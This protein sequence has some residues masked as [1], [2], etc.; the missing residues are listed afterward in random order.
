MT[1]NDLFSE[2]QYGFRKHR[3]CVT[4]L[5]AV[6]ENLKQLIDNGYPD[7][8]VYLDLKKKLLIPFPIKGGCVNLPLIE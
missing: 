7:D 3:S 6:T 2:C 1:D 4:Q 8:A 5:L